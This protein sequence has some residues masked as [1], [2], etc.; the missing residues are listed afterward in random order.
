M[1]K[2]IIL[3]ALLIVLTGCSY[4]NQSSAS[5]N[6]ITE[7]KVDKTT[8]TKVDEATETRAHELIEHALEQN[9]VFKRYI[10]GSIVDDSK[11]LQ[12]ILVNSNLYIYD[13]SEEQI[14]FYTN[15]LAFDDA[16]ILIDCYNKLFVDYES[17]VEYINGEY[18]KLND[19]EKFKTIYSMSNYYFNEL[20]NFLTDVVRDN[21][22]SEVEFSGYAKNTDGSE[23]LNLIF[24][25]GNAE[26]KYTITFKDNKIYN[27]RYTD[28]NYSLQLVDSDL[29]SSDGELLPLQ[30]DNSIK[31]MNQLTEEFEEVYSTNYNENDYKSFNI[32]SKIHID[33]EELGVIASENELKTFKEKYKETDLSEVNTNFEINKLVYCIIPSDSTSLSYKISNIIFDND[34]ITLTIYRS[35][36]DECKDNY[37]TWFMLTPVEK[38]KE[39]NNIEYNIPQ[40]N[41]NISE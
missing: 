14:K 23:T 24:N 39:I 3:L 33:K 7:S 32:G 13:D 41:K 26:R 22:G 21:S 8:D 27:I 17:G 31:E 18:K 6:S 28:N 36:D 12:F 16:L 20:Y 2:T 40:Y 34:S 10:N 19:D 15:P 11:N 25:R 9:H 37:S 38:D 4:N 29:F 5:S 30:D 1:K 35:T